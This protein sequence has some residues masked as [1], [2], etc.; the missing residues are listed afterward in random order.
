MKG[1]MFEYIT[2]KLIS[3]PISEKKSSP[4]PCD[5]K[6]DKAAVNRTEEHFQLVNKQTV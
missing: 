2:V 4:H 3:M 6:Q 5:P 1:N